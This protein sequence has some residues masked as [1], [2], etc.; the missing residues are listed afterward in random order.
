MT[1]IA[2]RPKSTWSWS[3]SEAPPHARL[4]EPEE[5]LVP[6]RGVERSRTLIEVADHDRNREAAEEHLVVVQ[7]G[8]APTCP[9]ERTRRASCPA[10]WRRAIPN[11]YRGSGP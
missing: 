8:S 3:R 2:K 9:L 4:N 1:G 11:A 10:P 5:H 7:I 6:L